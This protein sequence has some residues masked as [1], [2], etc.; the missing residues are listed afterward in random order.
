MN[1][2]A[3]REEVVDAVMTSRAAEDCVSELEE[4]ARRVVERMASG[5]P[6]GWSVV[7][8]ARV[9][10]EQAFLRSGRSG[11]SRS[12]PISELGDD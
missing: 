3:N 12:V 11:D 2:L 4:A 8:L 9:L 7:A 10:R 5:E 1:C 6:E